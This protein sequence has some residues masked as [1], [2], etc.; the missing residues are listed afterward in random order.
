MDFALI[1]LLILIGT[2]ALWGFDRW[3]W[4]DGRERRAKGLAAAGKADEA[5]L[6]RK[7]PIYVEYA[8]AFFPVILIV[9]IIRSFLVEP[10]R[11][12]SGSM[13]PS[14]YIGDFILVNKFAYG[15][16]LPVANNKIM[17]MGQP[18]RGE[19]AVFRFP[20]NTSINYIKR[21]VGVPG[22]RILYKDKKLYING[23][24]MDQTDG[25]SYSFSSG[26][27]A[28]GQALRFTE[29][30]DGVKHDILTT[31]R[32]D[33]P[34]PEIVVPQGQY[35]VMGDNRDQ[36]NDSR[37]WGFVPDQNLVGKAFLIWF[38]WDVAGEE[39]WFWKR[40][41]WNRIGNVIN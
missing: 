18:K 11:I 37:Y 9:F 7:E 34:L 12:P 2:G 22:D 16:R 27:D 30:L 6:A 38:S 1:M 32:P 19:V 29:S 36:S 41:V 31:N 28:L 5:V 20:G 17:D 40:I 15:V 23:R 24:L 4:A 26:G 8:R 39:E 3:I 35:F 25:R 21:V 13:L 33:P 14:L 10:F